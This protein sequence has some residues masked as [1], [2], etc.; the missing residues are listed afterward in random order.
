MIKKVTDVKI[1]KNKSFQI[2]SHEKVIHMKNI[3]FPLF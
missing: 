2:L 1:C 3:I